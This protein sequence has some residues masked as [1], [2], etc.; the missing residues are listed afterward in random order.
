MS[1]ELSRPWPRLAFL[2]LL[3]LVV[4]IATIAA[5]RNTLYYYGMISSQFGIAEAAYKGHEFAYDHV[6][7]GAAFRE[8]SRQGRHIPIEEWRQLQAS[9]QY[10]TFP[11]VD[12]PGL[13]YLI[14]YTSRWLDDHLTTRWALA[15]Q[16]LVEMASVILFVSC[17]ASVFGYRA[18]LSAC[19]V[20]VLAYP[21]IWPLASLPMRDVFGIGGFAANIAAVLSFIQTR[22]W[23][24][25]FRSGLLLV[26]GSVL[27]WVRP[28][29]Y[30]IFW[31]FLPLVAVVRRRSLRSRAA[32]ALMLFLIPWLLFG[33]PLRHF[34]VRHYGVA[35]TDLIGRALWEQMGIAKNNPYGFVLKDEA[36]LPWIKAYYGRDV[37][38]ASPEMNKL[39]GDYVRR[40]IREHPEFYL[41]TVALTCLEMAK[42]P[43]DFI[44]P[45]P[46][47]D[48][49]TSGLTLLE[50]AQ[51]HP[52]AFVFKLF[53]RVLLT[54][55]FYGGL[56]TTLRLALRHPSRRLELAVLMSPLVYA[57]LVQAATHFE[58][59]YMAV[60][61]WVLVL[62][63][64]SGLED[65]L[66]HRAG[67]VLKTRDFPRVAR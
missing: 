44:P 62:P 33:L 34:N 11:A 23:R 53:N 60:G 56:Y 25:W 16:V 4:R 36:L 40:V 59:R 19:L 57:V 28:Y 13:G 64:A 49:S 55:F 8:A 2:A 31:V 1:L 47:V 58:S 41:K 67:L 26:A 27:L 17:A 30:Y 54:A 22:G 52:V 21:F 15:V 38:Y 46:L 5:Y 10:S 42:T 65:A 24:S 6:L 45:F 61:A 37:E 18:A 32:F 66:A 48:Y 14:G 63:L 20:Y 9:G 43:L 51:Q 39:L 3:F 12:L 29:G 35:D 7:V 50:Y